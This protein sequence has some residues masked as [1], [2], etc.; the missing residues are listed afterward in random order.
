M[1]HRDAQFSNAVV[2]LNQKQILA[3]FE[4][5]AFMCKKAPDRVHGVH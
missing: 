2:N 4:L 5:R 1:I 3:T